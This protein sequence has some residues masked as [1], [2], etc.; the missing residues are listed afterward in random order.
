MHT[1]AA[2][3]LECGQESTNFPHTLHSLVPGDQKSLLYTHTRPEVVKGDLQR[4][5]SAFWL[6]Q[7]AMHCQQNTWP[8]GVAVGKVRAPK[9]SAH[10]LCCGTSPM[11]A[12]AVTSCSGAA[13]SFPK[14]CRKC[15]IYSCHS[16]DM[17]H[18]PQKEKAG[19][20][21]VAVMAKAEQPGRGPLSRMFGTGSV[22]SVEVQV[23]APLLTGRSGRGIP[24][25]R[26]LLAGLCSC[27]RPH[28]YFCRGARSGPTRLSGWTGPRSLR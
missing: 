13:S 23:G 27:G 6:C 24:G 17:H 19:R 9:H 3:L 25:G 5:H 10:F 22:R 4:G 1:R 2:A 26:R 11:S 28:L 12:A 14:S 15:H 7:S 21:S 8:Q 20:T 18:A 16:A